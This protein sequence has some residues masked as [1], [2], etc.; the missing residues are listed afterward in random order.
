MAISA[1][2]DDRRG[3]TAPENI[4]T[5]ATTVRSTLTP[6]SALMAIGTSTK[7]A[8]SPVSVMMMIAPAATRR[9][10]RLPRQART[11]ATSA[12]DAEDASR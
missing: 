8:G 5:T 12:D 10:T 3:A 1:S 9:A 2:V 4:S 7:N 11:A 6:T